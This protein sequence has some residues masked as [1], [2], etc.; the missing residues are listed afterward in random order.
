MMTDLRIVIWKEWLSLRR[1]QG[2][3]QLLILTVSLAFWAVWLPVQTGAGWMT[4]GILSILISVLLPALVVAVTVPA[5]IAGERERKTL[6]T[7]LSTRLPDDTILFGKLVVPV[8]LGVVAMVA[9]LIVGLVAANVASWDGSARFYD[10]VVIVPDLI[11]GF[12][13]AI[14]AAGVGVAISLRARRVQDAQQTL[15]LMLMLPAMILGAGLLLAM[16]ALGGVQVAA[17]RFDG[18]NGWAVAALVIVILAILDIGAITGAR[19]RFRRGR[20]IKTV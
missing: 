8:I 6:S 17:E 20:L 3:R 14:A 2:R 7:L 12:Q 15:T 11:V 10:P 19:H 13:V 4:D 1:G 16:Q 5:T 9:V 18:V